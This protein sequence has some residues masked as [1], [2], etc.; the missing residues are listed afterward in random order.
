MTDKVIEVG[1]QG[2]AFSLPALTPEGESTVS[3]EA[4]KGAPYLLYFYPRASTPGCTTQACALRDALSDLRLPNG[5]TLK[6]LGVSPDPL[7]KLERFSQKQGLNFPLLSDEE[8]ILAEAYGVWVP[9]KLYG[10]QF[11]GIERSSFLLDGQG[12]VCAMKRRVRP[13]EHVSWVQGALAHLPE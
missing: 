6:V 8:H 2:P 4:L 13:A 7:K 3:S 1:D 5:E 11:M 10:R 9:K 12:R